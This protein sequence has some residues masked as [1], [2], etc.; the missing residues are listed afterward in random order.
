[1]DKKLSLVIISVGI[2]VCITAVVTASQYTVDTPLYTVRMEKASSKMN[3]L[4]T[5]VRGFMYTTE[6]GY[7]LN[8]GSSKCL[9]GV[10]PLDTGVWTCYY[11]TCGGSTCY[12]T[13]PESCLGTCNDPT[14]PDTCP[15]TCNPTCD[16]IT[17]RISCGF[18]CWETCWETCPITCDDPTCGDTCGDTCEDTCPATCDDPTC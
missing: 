16:L 17:C 15:D 6:K 13:C 1:M 10:Q 14:C 9:E 18:T 11:S 4:P 5:A 2:A 3:F 12:L 7:I 8:C